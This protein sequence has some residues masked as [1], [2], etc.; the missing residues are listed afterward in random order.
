[1]TNDEAK[2]THIPPGS[3]HH[4]VVTADKKAGIIEIFVDGLP[5]DSM[6]YDFKLVQ[7]PKGTKFEIGDGYSADESRR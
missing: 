5:T 1:M 3:W 2:G 7:C 6:P 4:L